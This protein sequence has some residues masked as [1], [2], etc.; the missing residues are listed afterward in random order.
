MPDW[1]Y[2]TLF[3]PLLFRLPS[4]AARDF[5]LRAMGGLSRIPGGS[6]IIRTLGHME[7]HPMLR[8]DRWGIRLSCPVG[9]SGGLDPCGTARQALS[10]FGFGYIEIGPVSVRPIADPRPIL[11]D[12]AQE[13]IHYPDAY[14]NIGLDETVRRLSKER[15]RRLP[16]LIRIAHHAGADPEQAIKEHLQLMDQLAPYAAGFVV[17]AID[18]DWKPEQINSM[19]QSIREAARTRYPDKPLLL[20]LPLDSSPSLWDELCSQDH[21]AQWD[22]ITIGDFIRTEEG[23]V[24]GRNGK[25]DCLA[26]IR[27]IRDTLGPSIP[28]LAAAGVHEPQDALDLLGEGADYI[29]LHSGLV[30]SG[31]GLPKRVNEAILYKRTVLSPDPG[32]FSFWRNWGWMCLLGL[33]MVLGGILA[34]IIAATTVILPY[35]EAFLGMDPLSLSLINERLL[36][37]M[38]HDRITLAGTMISIGILY[39]MLARFGL[40]CGHHWAKTALA[41]SGIIGFG[42]FFLYLGYGYFDPLHAAAAI[43]LFPMFILSMRGRADRPSRQEPNLRNDRAWRLAQWGQLMFVVLGFALALGGLVIAGVGISYVFVREDLAYLCM[44]PEM[45]SQINDRLIPLIAHDRAGFGGALLCDAAA[46]TIIALWGINQGERWIW[47]TL[48]LGGLPGFA[49]GFG[50]HIAIGYT[51]LLH[52]S[53]AIFAFLL[54]IAGLILLYPYL[55]GA[56]GS[57]I[58]RTKV[59]HRG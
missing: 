17:D 42:S 44:T 14:V 8:S 2:Q 23:A 36:Y 34:W 13:A 40:R 15:G 58:V 35:D 4:A 49:A 47:W 43:I 33:G 39:G 59:Q 41:T 37:F 26:K 9:L 5:T 3:R 48:L 55:M 28:I 11:R 45:I 54:Y 7:L 6:F 1:S 27:M 50:V 25:A 30:Y 46:I 56:R 24:I 32:P 53:P 57:S 22:G 31:P 12:V 16:Y 29:Q 10:Q 21:S 19:L 18:M 51:D 38:S 20:Y 52:L